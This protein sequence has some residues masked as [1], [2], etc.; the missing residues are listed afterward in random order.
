MIQPK[1]ISIS[2]TVLVGVSI[3]VATRATAYV[4]VAGSLVGKLSDRVKPDRVPIIVAGERRRRDLARLLKLIARRR[5]AV[6]APTQVTV[7]LLLQSGRGER[8]SR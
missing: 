3:A 8:V 1:R 6:V 5:G 4:E 7:A 2:H